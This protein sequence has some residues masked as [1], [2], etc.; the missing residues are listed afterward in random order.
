MRLELD[1]DRRSLLAD[2]SRL[3]DA[4]ID[5]PVAAVSASLSAPR[6]FPPL[7]RAT[8]PGDRVVVSIEDGV[9]QQDAVVAGVVHTLLEGDVRPEDVTILLSGDPSS[10][11]PGRVRRLLAPSVLDS[12]SVAQH[13]PH[14]ATELAYLA[15]SRENKP[16]Y[17]NR[18]LF[19]ADMVLPVGCLRPAASLGYLGVYSGLFPTYSDEATRQ[20]FRTAGTVHSSVQQKRHFQEAQEAAWLLGIHLMLQVVPGPG[21]SLLHVLAGEAGVLAEEGR[22]L[23]EAVWL[24]RLAQ[25]PQLV[26]AAIEG[27]REVQTWENFARALHAALAVVA[28]QG[29]VVLCTDLRCPPGPAL[30]RLGGEADDQ[31]ARRE[32]L[33]DRSHDALAALLLLDAR[34]RVRVYLMSGLDEDVVEGLG[35]G[36]VRNPQEI[37]R[38]T[39]QYDSC[40]L[41]GDA[42]RAMLQLDDVPE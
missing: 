35:V 37:T 12:V 39:R 25:S 30:Q 15:A 14:T 21:D 34:P 10:L 2:F 6:G 16:I 33:R 5:D 41:L 9:P 13:D 20:R 17:F 38:L 24:H 29:A 4:V 23:C 8:V 26:I 7:N 36:Y 19:D 11:D 31:T 22:E 27:G 18:L 3:Q 32:I 28:D 42:H 40:I 1:L